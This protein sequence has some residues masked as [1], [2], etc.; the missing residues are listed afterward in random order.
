MPSDDHHVTV[1]DIY[2]N[3]VNCETMQNVIESVAL[4][5]EAANG[6]EVVLLKDVEIDEDLTMTGARNL[7]VSLTEGTE[8]A[9]AENKKFTISNMNVAFVGSGT[10]AGFTAA[11]VELDNTS[12]LT[13]PASAEILARDFEEAGKYVTK[14]ADDTWSVANKF[15]LQIQMDG[16][17]PAIGFLNDTRRAYVIEASSDLVDWSPVEYAETTG[18]SEIAV[19][20]KW[21][22]PASGRCFRVKTAE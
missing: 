10:L 11:N 16:D 2:G 18:D 8:L 14:N 19:P 13:L 1:E 3:I 5:G 7:F 6:G 12:V 9:L 22:A 4:F 20:L 15:E 17:V 21:Q